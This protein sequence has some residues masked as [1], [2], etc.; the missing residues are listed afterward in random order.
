MDLHIR[1]FFPFEPTPSQAEMMQKLE[2]FLADGDEHSIFLLK[3]Y[4]GTG[5]S[6]LVGAFSKMAVAAG[7]PLQL[8]APTGR[9]AKVL[10]G[11]CEI[12][13]YTIHR[14][15]YRA[16]SASVLD[17]GGAGGGYSVGYN[18]QQ[19]GTLYI[20]DEASMISNVSEGYTPFGSGRLLDDLME[21]CFS[22]DGSKM[23]LIGDDAQLPPVGSPYSPALNEDYLRG[24]T[25]DLTVGSLTEIVRQE[26][27]GEIVLTS[28]ELRTRILRLAGGEDWE[29]PL[30]SP[31]E[32]GGEITFI[33]GEDL[34]T[35]LEQSYRNV[36]KEE[37]ILLTRTNLEAET[38]NQGIRYQSLYLEEE[39]AHGEQIM[40]VR[41][42]YLHYPTDAMGRPMS[43]FIANGELLKVLGT[44]REEKM[45]GF[46]FREA[47][48][49]DAHG[50]FISAKI[51][52]DSLY[53][54]ATALTGEQR[55]DLYKRV[56][57]DYPEETTKRGLYQKLKRDP[58][59]NALQIKYAYAM[60]VH[61]AQGGGWKHV[62]LNFGYLTPEMIDL[63]FCRWLYT[64]ITRATEHLYIISPPSFIFGDMETLVSAR[65]YD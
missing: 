10:Q 54:G 55:E 19:E 8:L 58:Y 62:F 11:Y 39:V 51:I 13:A 37:T 53:T 48:L 61:K 7:R 5:K 2:H 49:E 65:Y 57:E 27:A 60:T 56:S 40:V 22:I 36:G 25:S 29:E 15:I 12:P 16:S 4:A 14:T 43:G 47:E 1:D 26:A 50:G 52:L 34:P 59:L 30:L 18:R 20:V 35:L 63:S 31:P 21:Y 32:K 3:G 38:F 9:A 45:Y 23:L 28:Y 17:A 44:R 6:S 64:A 24:Y 42:N 33:T 41:N 46:T